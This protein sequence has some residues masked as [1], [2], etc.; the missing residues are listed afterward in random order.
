MVTVS[1]EDLQKMYANYKA[2][3][4]ASEFTVWKK[5]LY[6]FFHHT[7]N[8]HVFGEVRADH[9]GKTI[10]S[11]GNALHDGRVSAEAALMKEAKIDQKEVDLIFYSADSVHAYT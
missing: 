2:E 7:L 11:G 1:D 5:N 8:S 10:D 4:G 9:D 6:L 3:G